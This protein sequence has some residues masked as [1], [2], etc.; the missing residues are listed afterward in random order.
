MSLEQL[1]ADTLLDLAE[2]K[3]EAQRCLSFG[4]RPYV[5]ARE[6]MTLITRVEQAELA[7]RTNAEGWKAA[8][9]EVRNLE[10]DVSRA[11]SNHVA[12]LNEDWS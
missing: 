11:L 9:E 12:D 1:P 6:L 7:A 2:L 4:K 8:L 10:H 3:E 5:S